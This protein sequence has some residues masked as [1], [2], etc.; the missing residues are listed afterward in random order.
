MDRKHP[1]ISLLAGEIDRKKQQIGRMR[2]S[3]KYSPSAGG[4]EGPPDLTRFEEE[5]EELR[6]SLAFFREHYPLEEGW[7]D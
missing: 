4:D 1:A 7:I 3:W 6:R 2:E 5:L